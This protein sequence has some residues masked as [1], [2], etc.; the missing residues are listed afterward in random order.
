[1]TSALVLV[2]LL[3]RSMA[4]TDDSALFFFSLGFAALHLIIYSVTSQKNT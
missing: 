2:A 1:M 4:E 3:H